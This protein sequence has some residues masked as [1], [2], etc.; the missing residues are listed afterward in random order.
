[1]DK[2]SGGR[3]VLKEMSAE[4]IHVLAWITPWCSGLPKQWVDKVRLPACAFLSPVGFSFS[5]VSVGERR[6]RREPAGKRGWASRRGRR[7][8]RWGSAA[9]EA[10]HEGC[11]LNGKR[12]RQTGRKRGEQGEVDLRRTFRAVCAAPSEKWEPERSAEAS[13]VQGARRAGVWRETGG[14]EEEMRRG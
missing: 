5:K 8:G 4:A 6:V 10:V 11:R 7:G 12:G 2:R 1:M 9:S 14:A 13:E 3:D